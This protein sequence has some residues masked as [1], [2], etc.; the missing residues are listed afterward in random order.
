MCSWKSTAFALLLNCKVSS[1]L[2]TLIRL[3]NAVTG[4]TWRSP[5]RLRRFL[6]LLLWCEEETTLLFKLPYSVF[7]VMFVLFFF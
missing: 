5:R 4:F 1:R 6:L 2:L 7:L 3:L